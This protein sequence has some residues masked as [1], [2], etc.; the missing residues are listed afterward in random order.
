MEEGRAVKLRRLNAFRNKLPHVSA[1]ALAAVLQEATR[2]GVPEVHNRDAVRESR[3]EELSSATCATGEP[4]GPLI[5][6]VHLET[7]D[8]GSM[9]LDVAHPLAILHHAWSTCGP[10]AAMMQRKLAQKQCSPEDPWSLIMYSDEVVPGNVLAPMPSRKCQVVYYSFLE[11]G[12]ETLCHE[13]AWFCITVKR[14]KL[15]NKAAG[16][17]G[18]VVGSLLKL[19]FPARGLSLASTGMLLPR[20]DE[21]GCSATRFF[22]KLGIVVQDGAAHKQV[23]STRGDGSIGFCSLCLGLVTAGSGLADYDTTG[24]IQANVTYDNQL[25]FASTADMIRNA[26]RVAALR[27][28]MNNDEF[29]MHQQALGYTYYPYSILCDPELDG[30]IDPAKQYMHDWMHGLMANGVFNTITHMFLEACYD[31]HRGNSHIYQVV[32]EYIKGWR[33]PRSVGSTSKLHEIFDLKRRKGNTDGGHLRC[34]A[35]EGLSAYPVLAHFVR[36]VLISSANPDEHTC[37]EECKVFLALVDVLEMIQAIPHGCIAADMLRT[38]VHSFLNQMV[39]V[40]DIDVWPK[41]HWMLHF[42]RHLEE[43]EAL[44]SCFVHERKHKTIRR[45]GN[46]MFNTP[47]F[48][49]T[50]VKDI[51]CS[52][53]AKLKDPDVFNHDVGLVGGGRAPAQVMAAMAELFGADCSVHWSLT[54]RHSKWEVSSKHD[55]VLV[56]HSNGSDFIAGEVKAHMAVDGFPVTLLSAWKLQSLGAESRYA[57]WDTRLPTLG[58]IHTRTILSTCIWKAVS[59]GLV[60]TLL[61]L[62]VR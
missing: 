42:P 9:A 24:L 47:H 59:S 52:H 15:V 57:L 44:L 62:H 28:T 5:Q 19:F 20:V 49:I 48:D 34:Q 23:W 8:G 39:S 53:L 55:V 29:T 41:A 51:T 4:H 2:V 61:P 56:Q 6:T 16:S 32:G 31:Q 43:H 50:V 37:P 14:S 33:W 26:R 21:F 46:D 17:M 25:C 40:F 58:L 1:S 7:V 10:F 60:R 38:A 54:S 22:A 45:V 30:I 35:S 13:D 3:D 12:F 11:F 27:G 18:Q 36:S